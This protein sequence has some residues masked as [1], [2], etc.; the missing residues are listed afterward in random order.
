[1]PTANL[2]NLAVLAGRTGAS[3]MRRRC[4]S[5]DVQYRS[6]EIEDCHVLA[7][8]GPDAASSAPGA[9]LAARLALLRDSGPPGHV[10]G[11]RCRDRR[12]HPISDARRVETPFTG[13]DSPRPW[14]S[15]CAPLRWVRRGCSACPSLC[16]RRC[17]RIMFGRPG[18]AERAAA[19]TADYRIVERNADHLSDFATVNVPTLLISGTGSPSYLRKAVAGLHTRFLCTSGHARRTQPRRDSEPQ[20]VRTARPGGAG[21]GL[22]RVGSP[23]QRR[24]ARPSTWRGVGT[25]RRAMDPVAALR[26][27][28]FCW[29]ARTP[30][31]IG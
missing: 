2:D 16:C 22:P 10:Q 9:L 28:A 1:M 3:W 13:A 26:R 15:A 11:R 25:Y 31:P 12:L 7:S 27:V 14:R 18:I 24:T 21:D 6:T 19:L 23:G 17:P 4:S 20:G 30:T 8:T 5:P 29:N